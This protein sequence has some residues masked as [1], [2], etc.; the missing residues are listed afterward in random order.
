MRS[1][2]THPHASK[3]E[4]GPLR[5]I[6][7]EAIGSDG[8]VY[9]KL[10]CSHWLLLSWSTWQQLTR[11]RRACSLCLR[12]EPPTKRRAASRAAH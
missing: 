8:L 9:D 1:A 5:A 6:V 7:G 12:T 4:R 3:R 10:E 11:A 2:P